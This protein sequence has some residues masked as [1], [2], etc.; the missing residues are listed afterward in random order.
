MCY[1]KDS[2]R[3]CPP[4]KYQDGCTCR[5]CPEGTFADRYMWDECLPCDAGH[6]S[7]NYLEPAGKQGATVCGSCKAGTYSLKRESSCRS[8]PAGKS[9]HGCW[10]TAPNCDASW[11]SK[12]LFEIFNDDNM[13]GNEEVLVTDCGYR[14]GC[15]GGCIACPPG[16]Y[17][18]TTGATSCSACPENF[19]AER[20]S[21]RCEMCP[22]NSQS[23]PMSGTITNCQCN[24]GYTFVDEEIRCTPCAAGKYKSQSGSAA[25]TT[26]PE[27]SFTVA[28]KTGSTTCTTCQRGT[29]LEDGKNGTRCVNTMTT[30]T[31]T[32]MNVS[33]LVAG[34]ALAICACLGLEVAK[35]SR[36]ARTKDIDADTKLERA[37]WRAEV[38]RKEFATRHA[39]QVERDRRAEERKTR[40][41]SRKKLETGKEAR[42]A[43]L[44]SSS[45]PRL[46]GACADQASGRTASSST[47]SSLNHSQDAPQSSESDPAAGAS[48]IEI[49]SIVDTSD[50]EIKPS[51]SGA[52]LIINE[53]PEGHGKEPNSVTAKTGAAPA[54][55]K[56]QCGKL[57]L[58]KSADS[59]LTTFLGMD[60]I[61]LGNAL[62]NPMDALEREWFPFGFHPLEEEPV[63]DFDHEYLQGILEVKQLRGAKEID[64]DEFIAEQERLFD[65]FQTRKHKWWIAGANFDYV[66]Y[67]AVGDVD[68]PQDNI[69]LPPQVLMSFQTG[70]YHGGPIC[71]VD[72]DSGQYEPPILMLELDLD[73]EHT[74]SFNNGLENKA[75]KE[76]NLVLS[77]DL[78]HASSPAASEDDFAILGHSSKPHEKGRTMVMVI[79]R[80]RAADKGGPDRWWQI[81]TGLCEKSQDKMSKLFDGHVTQLIVS[82]QI[83]NARSRANMTLA[84]FTKDETSQLAGLEEHHVFAI[85]IYTSDSFPFFN[86]P[87]RQRVKPHPLMVTMYFL[88]QAMKMLT[89]VEAKLRP[90][91]Y[92]KTKYL[93]RGMRNMTLDAD[94]FFQEGGTE[95]VSPGARANTHTHGW[96]HAPKI[97][98][99]M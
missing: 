93:W 43:I 46:D 69:W 42:Q 57:I 94:L 49:A 19:Y 4:G 37:R 6:Y 35:R 51:P 82:L 75:R 60:D 11:L 88:D 12:N 15:P 77:R 23:P 29:Q 98:G 62:M 26:C 65:E 3:S 96:M 97:R 41:V 55:V 54:D 64:E 85:R 83:K 1:P 33:L 92:N 89:T 48:A 8:C 71:A 25:C 16:T 79:I 67:G 70:S 39:R 31:W 44:R 34:V 40:S 22:A 61:M 80:N 72:Y 95:L 28:G 90:A 30:T 14:G 27:G 38:R 13:D 81:A 56:Y 87:M 58:G 10:S 84:D 50:V 7:S 73:Y 36:A 17:A 52:T 2:C 21:S 99:L 76:F 59:V 91:E 20:E 63:D 74:G 68:H 9:S 47:A 5:L 18:N 45:I 32:T 66:R 24:A 78:A 53:E 86:N